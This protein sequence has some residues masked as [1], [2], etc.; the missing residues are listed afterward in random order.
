MRGRGGKGKLMM[1]P[2][3]KRSDV[4]ISW[5]YYWGFDGIDGSFQG[6]RGRCGGKVML[7]VPVWKPLS[8]KIQYGLRLVDTKSGVGLD[9]A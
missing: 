5:D 1:D 7:T 6:K 8:Y 3:Q 4:R 2:D 9:V